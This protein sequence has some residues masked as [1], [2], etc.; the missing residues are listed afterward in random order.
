MGKE[1]G[2]TKKPHNTLYNTHRNTHKRRIHK[3]Q[4]QASPFTQPHNPTYNIPYTQTQGHSLPMPQTLL[5]HCVK[6]VLENLKI[7][8]YVEAMDQLEHLYDYV[9]ASMSFGEYQSQEECSAD[10]L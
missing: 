3:I 8:S 4:P 1:P 7:D 2:K 6:N 10:Q 9:R 5:V